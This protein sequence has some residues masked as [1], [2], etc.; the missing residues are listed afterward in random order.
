M[1]E[2]IEAVIFDID[3]TLID[4]NDFH[5]RAWVKAFAEFGKTVKF[6]EARRQVGK[7]GDQYLPVF[8]SKSEIR[9]FGKDLEDY[10]G[11]F[12]KRN[13]LPKIRPFPKVR[14]LFQKIKSDGKRIAL[15]SSAKA[16][17]LERYKKIA[18]IDDLIEA[19]TSADDAEKSKPEP[20]IFQAAL[21][22]LGK[23]N[24]RNVVVVG[25]TAYDAEAARKI[26]L[27]VIGVLSGGWT[28]S[29]LL[30]AGCREVYRDAAEILEK[31]D[32]A[33]IGE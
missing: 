10:R 25:D 28:A 18:R 7:G 9:E 14:E 16:D 22:R 17:E 4:S 31:Y 8:L 13:Y 20:D 27:P 33:L 29:E 19:E 11:D 12:F 32:E 3:G 2:M 1:P 5:A 15:A 21:I 30:S 24:K 26:G 23:I 6:Y